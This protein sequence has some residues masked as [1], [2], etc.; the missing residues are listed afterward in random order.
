[1][2]SAIGGGAAARAKCVIF[3][4]REFWHSACFL[5]FVLAVAAFLP[6]PQRL[7]NSGPNPPPTTPPTITS[8][9]MLNSSPFNI[10]R[11]NF[12]SRPPSRP[13]P[14]SIRDDGMAN[15]RKWDIHWVSPQAR[16]PPDNASDHDTLPPRT[17]SADVGGSPLQH[18][19]ICF[20]RDRVMADGRKWDTCWVSPHAHL[21]PPKRAADHDILPP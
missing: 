7:R 8:R 9:W 21:P 2:Q 20:S 15:G 4:T 6:A 12:R 19:P 14:K 18:P 13:I 1:M 5:D 11:L 3:V 10:R 16:I 17:Q